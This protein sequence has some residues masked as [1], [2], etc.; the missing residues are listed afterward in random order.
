MSARTIE[1]NPWKIRMAMARKE[2]DLKDLAEKADVPYGT[3]QSIMYKR[4][5]RTKNLGRIAK[6]LDVD[7]TDLISEPDG[8]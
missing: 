8:Q 5:T 7:P 6:A 1:V 2:L 3:V 4:K